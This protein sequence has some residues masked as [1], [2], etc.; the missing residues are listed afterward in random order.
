MPPATSSSCS[1]LMDSGLLVSSLI[2][3]GLFGL[4]S[5]YENQRS[6]VFLL[7]ELGDVDR[8]QYVGAANALNRGG[9]VDAAGNIFQLLVADGFWFVGFFAHTGW[10]VGL[11]VW[12]VGKAEFKYDY[13]GS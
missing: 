7:P 1:S 2:S 13:V 5:V 11:L 12:F 6:P 8:A 10:V 9:I 3:G 4:V